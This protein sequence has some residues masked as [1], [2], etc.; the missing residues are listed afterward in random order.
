MALFEQN[1]IDP[2]GAGWRSGVLSD[3][4]Q[5]L[6]P[7]SDFP[8]TFSQNAFRR[9]LLWL[10]FVDDLSQPG[11]ARCR[12]D[13]ASYVADCRGWNGQVNTARPLIIAFGPDALKAETVDGYHAVGWRVI[14][15]WLDNDPGPWPDGVARDPGAPFWS[16]CF[17]GMQ[18]FV[19]M[20]CPA[21]DRRQSRNL[22]RYFIL[23]VNPRER[24]DIVAGDTPEGNRVR[25][26]IRTRC[27]A[28]DGLPHAP[29]LGSFQKGDLEWVQYGLGET[30]DPVAERCPLRPAPPDP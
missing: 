4:S 20:S 18:L 16:L 24:F 11:L 28:Y 5:R 13:L 14:Q 30:N 9:G 8:C 10:S 17:S 25:S 23:V 2:G 12:E 22:G 26:V 3:L 21:H 29:Q 7:P 27:E 19:N 1:E 6:S 15:D